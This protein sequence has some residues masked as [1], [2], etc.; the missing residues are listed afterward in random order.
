MSKGP[1]L[2]REHLE[3]IGHLQTLLCNACEMFPGELRP[4]SS[5]QNSCSPGNAIAS[6]FPCLFISSSY[7]AN[8]GSLLSPSPIQSLAYAWW[9]AL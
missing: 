6:F 4:F 7:I 3:G 5:P 1:L 8:A 9:V 2:G